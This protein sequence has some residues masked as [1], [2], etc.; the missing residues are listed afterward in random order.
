MSR[1]RWPM[2][3]R[4]LLSVC[5]GV[6]LPLPLLLLLGPLLRPES[7]PAEP[8]GERISPM[9][10]SEQRE[11]LLTYKRPC[12]SGAECDP[13]L[14]C[15][16]QNRYRHAFARRCLIH[17]TPERRGSGVSSGAAKTILHAQGGRSAANMNAYRLATRRAPTYAPRGIAVGSPGLTHP[18]GVI[19]IGSSLAPRPHRDTW[20]RPFT[21]TSPRR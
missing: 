18:L 6:L 20:G 7:G 10:D 17:G 1:V 12:E 16:Y 2:N 14:A 3:S 21:G 19:P 15:L 4:T 9:L 11:R 8:A 5:A 13:P